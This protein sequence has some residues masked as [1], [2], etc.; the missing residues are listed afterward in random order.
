LGGEVRVPTL[1]GDVALKIPAGTNGGKTFRLRGKGMPGARKPK[2]YGDLLATVQVQ[3]PRKL[4]A[5]ERELFQE[6]AR[7]QEKGT[8]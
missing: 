8:K 2:Q 3:V 4:S 5:R 6:L 7:L 1:D